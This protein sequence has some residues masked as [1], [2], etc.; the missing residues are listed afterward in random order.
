MASKTGLYGELLSATLRDIAPVAIDNARK[1]H[2][3]FETL[4]KNF[5]SQ[6][7]TEEMVLPVILGEE[8][9]PT[10][11][12]DASVAFSPDLSP[13][14]M[15]SAHYSFNRADVGQVRIPYLELEKNSGKNQ[16]IDRLAVHREA[17]LYQFRKSFVTQM[18]RQES[19]PG[20]LTSLF[21]LCNSDITEV[22]GINYAQAGYSSWRPVT[23]N[24]GANPDI[25]K[26]IRDLLDA[27][28]LNSEGVRPDVLLVGKNAWDMIRMYLDDHSSL[29]QVGSQAAIEFE[30]D[31][32]R[33]GGVEVRWD[34]DSPDDHI[35][36]VHTPS[37]HWRYLNDNFMKAEKPQP[38]YVVKNGVV[39]NTM[40]LTYPVIS[41]MSVGT[42]QRR[43]LGMVTA[44]G[45]GV[46][47]I[48]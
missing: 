28:L 35:Y 42:N 43:A 17:L 8:T 24:E 21:D 40:D 27:I 9:A 16:I 7:G 19:S 12:D 26:I 22:G 1:A 37:L 34:Y 14:L 25:K 38:V 32:V 44:V 47:G 46:P 4:R 31:S 6:V 3:L 39:H 13:A 10:S 33:F 5:K 2:P 45:N 36:A 20:A 15:E 30:W 29:T 11:T 23:H 41:V 18:H 48:A